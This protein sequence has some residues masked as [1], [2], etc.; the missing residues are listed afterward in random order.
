MQ[1]KKYI[2][3]EKLSKKKY[4]Y[5][6]SQNLSNVLSFSTFL[7]I[8]TDKIATVACVYH[9]SKAQTSEISTSISTSHT[10]TANRRAPAIKSTGTFER[11]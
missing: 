2:N 10:V 1:P 11:F 7:A 9:H 8:A 4:T 5:S 6:D 3:D